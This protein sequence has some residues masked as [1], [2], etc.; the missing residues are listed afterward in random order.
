MMKRAAFILFA[1]I[2]CA[3]VG[4][5]QASRSG[6]FY[7]MTEIKIAAEKYPEMNSWSA[8]VYARG[9][10]RKYQLSKELPYDVP[11]PAIYLSDDGRSVLVM[12]FEG[13]IEFYDER[14]HLVR[15]SPAFPSPTPDYE[16]VITCS[17]AGDM[18]GFA[19]SESGGMN[20]RLILTDLEGRE[21][22]D[23]Q[24]AGTHAGQVHVSST[25]NHILAG[26][27]SSDDEIRLSTV[28]FEASGKVMGEFDLLFRHAD[29][30]EDDEVV[31]LADRNVLLMAG[32]DPHSPAMRWTT[33]GAGRVIT[34]VKVVGGFAAAVVEEI[35][36]EAGEPVYNSPTLVVVDRTGLVAAT[37]T[38]TGTSLRPAVLRA[39]GS[40]VTV[41]SENLFVTLDVSTIH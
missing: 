22:Q 3:E 32:L 14:G 6:A 4:I 30:S 2:F 11:Y 5:T 41:S 20:P 25:G 18:A 27:Y 16:R 29:I 31:A 10:E 12:S 38:L 34:D 26:S 39:V 1:C 19:V 33:G 15:K 13:L 35:S 24:L 36:I 40:T 7:A 37:R 17:V 9:G 8:T 28:L 23:I 21:M